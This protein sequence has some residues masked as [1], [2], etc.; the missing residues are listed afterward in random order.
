MVQ[1]IFV[2]AGLPPELAWLAEVESTFNP[3]ARSPVGAC[4]LYQLM[5]ATAR[6]LGLSVI[7]PDERT[8]PAKNARAAAQYLR[9]LYG[10]FDDW[11]LAIAAYN[12][13]PGRIGRLLAGRPVKTFAGIATALPSETRMYVPK[14]LATLAVRAGTAPENLAAPK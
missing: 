2:A 3:D 6:S 5:A 1:E 8:D 4:G 13:G 10:R 12:A 14:V 9:Q 7:L 11:P